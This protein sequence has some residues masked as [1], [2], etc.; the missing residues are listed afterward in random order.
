MRASSKDHAA[1]ADGT[2]PLGH[3]SVQLN[4]PFHDD[5]E[6]LNLFVIVRKR[7][8]LTTFREWSRSVRL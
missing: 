2:P 1:A 7:C 6:H 5:L 8:F 3:A 4:V